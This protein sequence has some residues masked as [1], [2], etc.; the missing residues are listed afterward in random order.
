MGRDGVSND[1]TRLAEFCAD[2][3][4]KKPRNEDRPPTA[5]L[6]VRWTVADSSIRSRMHG[7]GFGRVDNARRLAGCRRS[8]PGATGDRLTST[9]SEPKRKDVTTTAWSCDPVR[10]APGA[11]C[12]FT[13][14]F[15]VTLVRALLAAVFALGSVA[16]SAAQPASES[17]SVLLEDDGHTW[18]AYTNQDEFRADVAALKPTDSVRITYQANALADLT[19]QIEAESGD[20]IVIDKYTP[21]NGDLLV[22]RANLLAQENLQVTQEATIHDGKAG[23]FHI[24]SVTTLDGKKAE[25]SN[26]D[27]PAVPVKTDLADQ[28]FVRV[29][30]E[31]RSRAL[32]KLCK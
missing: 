27:L 21:S 12:A 16:C 20:W 30:A 23:P 15:G 5:A 11:G 1:S 22:K 14:R 19:Y 25:L 4:K 24:V 3:S 32:A 2:T 7:H 8:V 6:L 31:M 26:V 17:F 9:P 13:L 28:T 10:S 29:V 18:C